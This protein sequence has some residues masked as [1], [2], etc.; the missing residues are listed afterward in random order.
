VQN[1]TP[2]LAYLT[3]PSSKMSSVLIEPV[4]TNAH[5]LKIHHVPVHFSRD[6]PAK[7]SS[8]FVPTV[9]DSTDAS[10]SQPS[11]RA[12]LRGR[13]LE[14]HESVL[15]TS[16]NMTGAI[17]RELDMFARQTVLARHRATAAASRRGNGDSDEDGS[18]ISG[19]GDG[20]GDG[21]GGNQHERVWV[22]DGT[23][24]TITTWTHDTPYTEHDVIPRALEFIAVSHALHDMN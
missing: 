22:I 11:L 21:D 23:F 1:S 8:Y 5:V 20:D 7:V 24:K 3:P 2:A 17:F 13:A 6:S 16:G 14:G 19:G 4:R 18:D 10:S 12:T 15:S 9:T